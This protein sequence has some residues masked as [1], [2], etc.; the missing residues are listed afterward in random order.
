[1]ILIDPGYLRTLDLRSHSD[2]LSK[3]LV[4]IGSVLGGSG[5]GLRR[6]GLTVRRVRSQ[7][8]GVGIGVFKTFIDIAGMSF[9]LRTHSITADLVLDGLTTLLELDQS[10]IV[11]TRCR[12]VPSE[13]HRSDTGRSLD[14]GKSSGSGRG[15]YPGIILQLG[16]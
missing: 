2:S 9:A 16:A 7:G 3:I 15:L 5:H 6:T 11:V 12:I 1:M 14:I 10:V 8:E 4:S 13:N